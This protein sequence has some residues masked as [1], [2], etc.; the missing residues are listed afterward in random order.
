MEGQQPA[1][2]V[3]V[4]LGKQPGYAAYVQY[5]RE[6]LSFDVVVDLGVYGVYVTPGQPSYL[7]AEQVVMEGVNG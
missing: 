2:M 4:K 5:N 7:A 6:T 3:A 1:K